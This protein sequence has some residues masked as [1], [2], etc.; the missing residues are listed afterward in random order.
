MTN[1]L[2]LGLDIGIASVGVGIIEAE[3]GK[4]IH[5]SSRIFPAAN[6]DNNAERRGF[7][8]GRRLTRRKKH[9]VKRVRDLFENYNITTDFNNLNLNPYELRVKGLT[10]ELTNEEL[11]AALRNISKRR[12]ISYLDDA[13]D[14]ANSGK[15]DYAKSVLANKELL[16]T[17]TPGQIQLERLNKYGQLRGDFDIV[18]ENGEIH[19]VINVFSTSDYR[20]EAEKILQT[21]SQFNN[22]INQEFINDYIDILVSKRKYY[23]GPGNEKSRTDYGRYRTDGR[24]LENIFDI[25]VGKCTFYPEEYRAAKASYTAQEFNF[26]NDLNNLTLPTE[27]KKLSIEEKLYLVDYAKNTPVLGP[28]KLL[29]EIAKLVDCKKEDI[30]GFRIDNKEKPDMHTFEV[31]R[32]MSKLD[33]VDIQTLSR[34]TFDELARILTLNTEREGIEEAILK[35]LPNQFTNEQI[36]EL[37]KFRKDKSQIFGKGWHNFSVKLMLELIPELYDT[38]EEQMTILTR[39]GKTSANKKEVKRTKY[40]NENDVTEEIYNPVVAKSVR[41]AIKIINAS[42]KEWGEFDNIVIEMPRE[43]NADD[44]RKFIKK[45]QDANAKEKKDSEERAATLYNGKT[46]LPSNIFHGHNQ[47]ATKIRLWY[48]QGERCI[49][50]GQKIDI[51]D[52][53]HNH[54]MYEIDHVLPL[55]LSFDDSL[56]NKVLVLATANQE[57]GQKTPFQSIPQMKSA[58]SYREFKS[59]V[60]GCKGLSKK[61]REYL[62]TEEDINKIEVKQKFIERNLVDTRYASRV[63]L[64][65]LQDSLK[66]MNKKTRVSVVRGQFT[67]QLRRQWKID[68]S[69]ETYHHHAIDAL[70]IAASSQLRLWKKQ[71]D[72]MFEDYKN[73]QKVDLETGELLSDNEYKELVFQSPYQGFVNTISSKAFED[74]ILFSYQVDSKVNRKISDATIYATR[75]AK[76]TKDKKEETY[77]LGK[78]KD[79]Y[80]QAGYDAF[81]KRYEKDKSAF[82]MYQKDPMTWEKVIEVILNDYCEFDDK[83]KETGNPFEK[84]RNENGYIRKYSRKG[85][86]TEIKSLKYYDSKLGNHID[87]TPENSKNSVVLQSINPWRAD[88]YFNPKTLK[89]E[90]MGLKYSDL[91]FEKGTGNYSISQDKY[92]EIKSREGISPKS[93]FKFTLYKNDLILIKDTINNKTLTARFNSKNDTSKHYVELKPDS[94]AKYDSEEVLIPV[95]GKVAKSGRFI[96]GINKT[97]ISIYKIKTDILGRK[98]FIKE[99]GDQPKLEFMKSSKNNK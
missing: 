51:N 93:E 53:I 82:L 91:S 13:E 45:M 75:Q 38:S 39:L 65:T 1:G 17:Q 41:Q 50:T 49:Y 59:Y 10:E 28:D 9:R 86:G 47:L 69:R 48:Q 26:L 24:T 18:D 36:E 96:K 20:K 76:L 37:I 54:N 14:D 73:G 67:S 11:F 7:R 74:E 84:Y 83:G 90:L 42:V 16:K 19:R 80:S 35:D 21:Q 97:G 33:K 72:T 58:W 79:I 92:D 70:I 22:A 88:L 55:S 25:L 78:I 99:E 87:I 4:V 89:Y 57:K 98:H 29:K 23:H 60:L 61:K 32:T 31:Y 94:K 27:T 52:L 12:G 3:T 68:K 5:A 71:G 95:F 30:K 40:I 8:G 2:V 44:E 62:L 81:R 43:T 34:E 77:V 63:V 15:T 46:E 56:A 85:K 64:N 6:A 66:A